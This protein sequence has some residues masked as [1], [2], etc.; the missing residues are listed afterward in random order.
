MH[1]LLGGAHTVS[2]DATIVAGEQHRPLGERY[3]DR[4]VDAQL[5]RQLD[6]SLGRLEAHQVEAGVDRDAPM[7]AP[8]E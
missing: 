8:A 4:I 6:A 1:G 2:R 3:E 7:A 5:D